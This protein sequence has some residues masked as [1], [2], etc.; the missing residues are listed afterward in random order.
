MTL[1]V[2]F[3]R[4]YQEER[5][6]VARVI[7]SNFL[8]L[9]IKITFSA[10]SNSK[11]YFRD[12]R[13][14]LI[15]L[16]G[17]FSTSPSDWLK[18]KSLPHQPLSV[19]KL[20]KISDFLPS[21]YSS[22]PVIYGQDS[23]K[24]NFLQSSENQITLRLDI[25]GSI[26]FMLTRYEEKVS[27]IK[28]KFERFP[29]SASLAYQENFLH[30]PIVNEYVEVLW[31]C[32]NQL[33]PSLKRQTKKFTVSVS[34]DVDLPFKYKFVKPTELARKI[35]KDSIKYGNLKQGLSNFKVW[36]QV[37]QGSLEADPFNTF[38]WIMDLSDRY[39][40]ISAFYFITD[41]TDLKKD[42]NYS[43]NSQSV[44]EILRTISCRGHEI[45]L[46]PS[47][48]T[49]LDPFQTKK[50][51]QRLVQICNE[52]GIRQNLWGGR[53]H[54]LRWNN[55]R[56]WQNWEDAGLTYD[57]TLT[58]ADMAGF[59][60]GTCYEFPVYNLLTRKTLKLVERPLIVMESSV[61][62]EWYMGLKKDLSE[63]FNYIVNLKKTCRQYN[64]NFTLLWH[65][66]RFEEPEYRNLYQQI[67]SD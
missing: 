60:C 16:E 38:R 32:I 26:F 2:Q 47:F 58:F 65:N 37:R 13:K 10:R 7:F 34:H 40:L 62:D 67:I 36:S 11:I 64:G 44:R 8:G 15:I 52:E 14:Q 9:E 55:P 31:T 41:C 24:N 5:S 57:S 42:G 50:E 17:L 54:Y 56:T 66:S 18:R 35:A 59:R 25:F 20:D 29:T 53:Q 49:Y 45:G 4:T 30:R 12:K 3:P 51:F 33:W 1:C 28:D 63:A 61:L 39:G 19:W 27:Q 46:H 48:N 43:I 6:Y 23:I 21:P 22:L